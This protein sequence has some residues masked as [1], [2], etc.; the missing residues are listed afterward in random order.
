MTHRR[1]EAEAENAP[2]DFYV[3]TGKCTICMIPVEHAPGIFDVHEDADGYSHCY[4]VRQPE[5]AAERFL[6]AEAVIGS[7]CEAVRYAGSDPDII[8]LIRA[9]GREQCC[10]QLSSADESI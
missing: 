2:G 10:D 6:A 8:A 1:Y 3:R 7:C 4:V 5:T 9:D